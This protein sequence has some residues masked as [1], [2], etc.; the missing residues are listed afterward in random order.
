MEPAGAYIN[1]MAGMFSDTAETFRESPQGKVVLDIITYAGI[2]ATAYKAQGDDGWDLS[3]NDWVTGTMYKYPHQCYKYYISSYSGKP[4]NYTND[5]FDAQY[6]YLDSI[7]NTDYETLKNET[8]KLEKIALDCVLICPVVQNVNYV[9]ISDSLDLPV[10]TYLP[11]F[12]WGEEF[13]DV[14]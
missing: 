1:I 10:E 3:P 13:G 14:K 4:N 5:E 11:G 12:G 8:A 2:G 7:R 9:L 6:E